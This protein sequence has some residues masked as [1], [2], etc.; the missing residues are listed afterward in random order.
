MT[1]SAVISPC[2]QYRYRL[3]R[4]WDDSLPRLLW[5]MLNPSTAD[6]DADDPTIRRV[7]GFTKRN[8]FGGF[9][10]VNLADYRSTDPQGLF[11]AP[12]PLQGP[13]HAL[14]RDE[15]LSDCSAVVLAWG[16]SPAVKSLTR[17][18]W[19]R[20]SMD[21]GKPVYRLSKTREGHPGHPLYIR[22]DAELQRYP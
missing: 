22:A 18:F 14:H 7:T 20:L 5:V 12:V 17:L 13:D 4:V 1:Q 21:G 11:N 15:A 9:D 10:V 2:G 8:G 16:A 19:I 3:T 6:A